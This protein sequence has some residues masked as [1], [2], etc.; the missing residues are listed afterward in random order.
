MD[1]NTLDLLIRFNEWWKTGIV[2]KDLKKDNKRDLFNQILNY[3]KD[4]QILAIYGLRR[5]GKSTLM[6]QLIDHLISNNIDPKN[7]LYISFDELLTKQT[8]IIDDVLETYSIFMGKKDWKNTYLFFDEI[9]HIDNW[10]AI[11]K[12]YYD[13]YPGLKIIISGSASLFIKKKSRESL[14]GRIYEFNLKTLTFR[15]F[16]KIKNINIPET[17][18]SVQPDEIQ[19]AYQKLLLYK[20]D[21]LV[22]LHDYILKGGF[23]EVTSEESLEKVHTYIKNS[24]LDRIIFQDIPETFEIREPT[25]LLKI[26][27]SISANPGGICEYQN[28]GTSLKVTR[29]TISNYMSYLEEAFLVRL[30]E[31]YTGSYLAGTR[32][33]KKA[34]LTDHGIIHV[35]HGKEIPEDHLLGKIVEN[36]VVNHMNAIQFWRAGK[37]EVDILQTVDTEKIPVEVKYRQEL[38]E[39]DVQTIK[40]VMLRFHAK[41]GIMVTKDMFNIEQDTHILYLPLWFFLLLY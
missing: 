15:E 1:E 40:K 32:K 31:N 22:Q 34:Y 26:L 41:N 12:R 4:K 11:I 37:E 9:Q 5:T 39:K 33:A 25:L 19:K 21:L 17:T 6:Y 36:I 20:K 10:Q 30:T 16:I 18:W 28:L 7:I 24:I 38:R 8:H 2:R 14:A 27:H 35:L 23:I 29:Q 13:I 3:L